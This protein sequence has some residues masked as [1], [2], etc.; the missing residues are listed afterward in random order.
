VSHFQALRFHKRLMAHKEGQN[1]RNSLAYLHISGSMHCQN[2]HTDTAEQQP[3]TQNSKQAG[4]HLWRLCSEKERHREKSEMDWLK[5]NSVEILRRAGQPKVFERCQFICAI[6]NYKHNRMAATIKQGQDTGYSARGYRMHMH[7]H[8]VH[9]PTIDP[10]H[11]NLQLFIFH[12][13]RPKIN[14]YLLG[15][16][17]RSEK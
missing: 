9:W 15:V 10:S 5:G 8:T 1:E 6:N 4:K 11:C 3:K 14:Y 12:F 7:M 13:L 16:D 2:A 17:S